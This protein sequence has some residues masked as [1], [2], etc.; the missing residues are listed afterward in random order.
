M[1]IKELG[2]ALDGFRIEI[3][4]TDLSREVL[5]KAKAGL[6]TQFEAQRGL[7]IH[8]LLKYF[9]QRGDMWQIAPEI[10]AMVQYRPFNLLS[11]FSRLGTFDLVMCRN[12]LIY[13][14][15]QTKSDVLDRLGR[16]IAQDGYL[17]LGAAETTVG[18]TRAFDSV[19]EK[20]G[21]YAPA[22]PAAGKVVRF[23][24]R[25]RAS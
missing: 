20:R 14:D 8:L 13:F 10:R 19:P 1:A 5:H 11:D 24:A 2:N 22:H 25:S 17:I 3:V 23:P 18:L 21:L 7:P 9:T 15:Q 12:V 16:T 6:Y 4:A